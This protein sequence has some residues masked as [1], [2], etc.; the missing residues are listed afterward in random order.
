MIHKSSSVPTLSSP[1]PMQDYQRIKKLGSGSFGNVYLVKCLSDSQLYVQKE[2]DVSTMTAKA[3]REAMKEVGFLARMNGSPYIIHLKQHF[4][5]PPYAQQQANPAAGQW[6]SRANNMYHPSP[7]NNHQIATKTFLYIIME[8]ADGGD[9]DQR[10]KQQHG[11]LLSEQSILHYLAQI[12]LGLHSIHSQHVLHRDM[13][14]ENMFLQ[15]EGNLIKIGDFGISKG[16]QN[17][18]A[19][20]QTRIG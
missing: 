17:T 20:A 16:L 15:K 1:H 7:R 2:I 6:A 12:V 5:G 10:L 13:K 11:K 8:Y 4:E 3:K 19:Q 9:L 18:L 14:C